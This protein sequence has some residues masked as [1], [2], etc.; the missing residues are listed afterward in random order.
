MI[1]YCG[2]SY[3]F[4]IKD[5]LKK[6]DPEIAQEELK[7]FVDELKKKKCTFKHVVRTAESFYDHSCKMCPIN[8]RKSSTQS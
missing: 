3:D 4:S 7:L 6:P 8:R 2:F 1:W 5:K